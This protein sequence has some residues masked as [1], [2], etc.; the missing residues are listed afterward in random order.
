MDHEITKPK[1][2][3]RNVLYAAATYNIVWGIMA[4]AVPVRFLGWLGF[5]PMPVYPEL[6]Q[7]IGMI[8]GVYGIGYAIAARDPYRHWPIVLVGLLGKVFGPIGFLNAVLAGR[9]PVELGWTI[10]TNDLIWW[11]PFSLILWRAARA[12]QS[13]QAMLTVPPVLKPVDPLG[14]IVS[15]YGMSLRELS[16]QQPVLLVFLRHSGCTFCRETLSDLAD[17]RRD[18]ESSGVSIALVHMGEDRPQS[19]LLKYGLTD[20]H[21]YH[22]PFS[23][24][25]EAFGLT[26]GSFR[27]LLGAKVWFRGF[28]AILAGHGIGQLDGNGFRMPGAFVIDNGEVVRAYRHRSAADRPNYMRLVRP[29]DGC[30]ELTASQAGAT[31]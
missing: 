11:A 21:C 26:L 6:W 9:L 29:V 31:A 7:C 27:Q 30:L 22:D 25:Y 17:Q 5:D 13:Q 15:Q 24:L 23:Q 19:L 14:R 20:L 10:V 18:I 8:V 4:I 28:A 1:I 3:M 12:I 2:W 16:R